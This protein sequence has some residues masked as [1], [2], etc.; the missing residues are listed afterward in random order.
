MMKLRELQKKNI[1]VIG[2]VVATQLVVLG[3]NVED[4]GVMLADEV[5]R[6]SS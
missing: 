5:R 2:I 3:H 1:M 4:R 6:S